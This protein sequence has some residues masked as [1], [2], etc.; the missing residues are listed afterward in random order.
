[1][2][3]KDAPTDGRVF[4]FQIEETPLRD[5]RVDPGWPPDRQT[6]FFRKCAKLKKIPY[7]S[8]EGCP[9]SA[10]K[11]KNTVITTAYFKMNK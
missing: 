3:M 9:E 7:I 8:Y 11:Q 6:I 1:M 5:G 4:V 10:R 2:E